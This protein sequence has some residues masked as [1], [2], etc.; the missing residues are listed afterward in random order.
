MY[1]AFPSAKA[2]IAIYGQLIAMIVSQLLQ[3]YRSSSSL[4]SNQL[5][6]TISPVLVFLH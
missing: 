5:F 4:L 3:V 2:Q 1:Y 6:K